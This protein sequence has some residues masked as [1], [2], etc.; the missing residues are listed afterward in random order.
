M[1]KVIKMS[2]FKSIRHNNDD[3]ITYQ[4]SKAIMRIHK[5]NGDVCIDI[6]QERI[7]MNKTVVNEVI[8][9]LRGLI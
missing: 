4:T 1:G 5:D 7:K 2:D 6:N 3:S 8:N 9:I